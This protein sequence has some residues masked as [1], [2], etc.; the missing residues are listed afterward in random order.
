MHFDECIIL[1]HALT[2]NYWDI[3]VKCYHTD[4]VNTVPIYPCPPF[5]LQNL[6]NLAL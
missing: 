2:V 4:T 5:I 1:V 3:I 6:I